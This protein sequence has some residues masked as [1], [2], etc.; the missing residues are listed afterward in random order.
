MDTVQP[1]AG[2]LRFD[3]LDQQDLDELLGTHR[4]PRRLSE[5]PLT[6]AEEVAIDAIVAGNPLPTTTADIV[7]TKDDVDREVAKFAEFEDDKDEKP[8][9][10]GKK[11]S[12]KAKVEKPLP[13]A[14]ELALAASNAGD[15][16]VPTSVSVARNKRKAQVVVFGVTRH[17]KRQQDGKWTT[18]SG[19]VVKHPSLS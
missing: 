1:N 9:R 12:K 16:A 10:R 3:V 17:V 11:K 6:T 13:L 18:A 14:E 7:R 8:A 15:P 2:G 5:T 19:V 4:I